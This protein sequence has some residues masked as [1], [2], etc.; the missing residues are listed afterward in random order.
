MLE[1]KEMIVPENIRAKLYEQAILID[2]FKL[3]AP[4]QNEVDL[5]SE[6]LWREIS[7]ARTLMY[8][9]I[10]KYQDYIDNLGA[11]LCFPQK[12]GEILEKN[13]G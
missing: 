3:G 11:L 2:V 7:A 4:F 10:K 6:D 12:M 9:E 8:A 1:T 5:T 13:N